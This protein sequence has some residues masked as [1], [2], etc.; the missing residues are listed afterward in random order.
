MNS[1]G[2]KLCPL[3]TIQEEIRHGVFHVVERTRR[4]QRKSTMSMY[5]KLVLEVEGQLRL[6]TNSDGI[7]YSND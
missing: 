4:N 3:D 2:M 5:A 6:Y 7:W 1:I